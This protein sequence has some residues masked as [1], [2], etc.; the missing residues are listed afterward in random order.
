MRRTCLLMLTCLLVAAVASAE[1]A[2]GSRIRPLGRGE[3]R[4][5]RDAVSQSATVRRLAERIE[6]SDLIVMLRFGL[7]SLG[8][9]GTTELLSVVPGTRYVLVT[10]DPR[11]VDHDRVARL[12]HELTH[13]VELADAP[14]VTNAET[15]RTL[16]RRI[17]WPSSGRDNWE[18]AAALETARRVVEDLEHPPVHIVDM[19]H[20]RT[21]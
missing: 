8:K 6:D 1:P 14:G 2:V 20:A 15:M 12:G 18:T 19:A 4:L 16:F 9:A 3:Q 10:L 13:V 11:A 7:L 21:R 5:M 17:G